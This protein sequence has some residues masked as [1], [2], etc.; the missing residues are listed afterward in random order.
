MARKPRR[1]RDD[2]LVPKGETDT[3]HIDPERGETAG[4]ALAR[5]ELDPLARHASLAGSF[6]HS[7]AFGDSPRPAIT[8]ATAALGAE[9]NRAT[10]GDLTIASRMLASQAVSLDA[11]FTELARRAGNNLGHYPETVERYMRLALKAQSACRSTL[12]ALAKLHQ[13]REQTV[14]H[15]HV[16]EGGQAIVADQFHH[17]SGGAENGKSVDQSDATGKFGP[18]AA[19]PGPNAQ[20]RAVPIPS[21]KGEAAVPDARRN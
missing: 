8:E 3:L 9:V 10:N 17:H 19:L 7:M 15:V 1:K 20:R 4:R 11:I 5:V 18:C 13:P 6:A 2:G 12:E 16:N 14:R 21:G